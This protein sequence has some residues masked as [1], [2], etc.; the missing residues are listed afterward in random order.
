MKQEKG[1][2]TCEVNGPIATITLSR[3]GKRN[4]MTQKM[5]AE[6]DVVVRQVRGDEGLR[7][8]VIRG[9]EGTFCAGDDL[10]ELVKRMNDDFDNLRM[11]MD[12]LINMAYQTRANRWVS[13]AEAEGK[14]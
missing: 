5:F 4:S 2:V 1:S 6:L 12:A 11:V 7:V 9:G 13:E 14:R 8:L 3:P 10:K